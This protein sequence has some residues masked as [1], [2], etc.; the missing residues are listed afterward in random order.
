MMKTL[1][2][3]SSMEVTPK[4]RVIRAFTLIELLVVIAIIAILAAMLLPALASA[5]FKAIRVVS[6]S[7]QKQI[8]NSLHMCA[9]DNRDLLPTLDNAGSW[10]WDIPIVS[11]T[12]PM[13]NN[14]CTKKIFYCPSTAP[15]FTDGENWAFQN[16]LWNY[17]IGGGFNITGYAFALGG[18]NS[19][20]DRQYQNYKIL[21]ELHTNSS[22][23]GSPVTLDNP[24]TSE[25][26]ADVMISTGLTVPVVGTDNFI[27]VSGGFTQNGVNYPHIS[28]HVERGQF[29]AGGNVAYKDGHAAWKKFHPINAG[30]IPG[31]ADTKVRT[32]NNAPYFW[33]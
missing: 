17:G 28:A 10:A 32:G 7:N 8:S 22:A 18:N 25:L 6:L 24:S 19:K 1:A 9:D 16:S 11:G 26:V 30:S 33:W 29:P 13:L 4:N 15:R 3:I 2:E 23:P 5:K 12:T 27:S 21:S 14:G 31:P 20:I